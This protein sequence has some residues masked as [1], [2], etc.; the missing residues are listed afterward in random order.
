MG[1]DRV[2]WSIL[3]GQFARNKFLFEGLDYNFSLLLGRFVVILISL[4]I[5]KGAPEVFDF[6]RDD[7]KENTEL[8]IDFR[9]NPIISKIINLF[10]RLGLYE[11]TSNISKIS[12]Q[13]FVILLV[14]MVLSF[15]FKKRYLAVLL[16]FIPINVISDIANTEKNP[17]MAEVIRST[18]YYPKQLLIA[19]LS[20]VLILL[21]VNI[22]TLLTHLIAVN[23]KAMAIV[24]IGCVFISSCAI[25][26]LEVIK[27]GSLFQFLYLMLIY[28]MMDSRI[29]LVDFTGNNSEY[30]KISWGYNYL[31]I[32]VAL[33]IPLFIIRKLRQRSGVNYGNN[34]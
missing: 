33:I 30:F 20:C 1:V 19:W 24:V 7:I 34:M 16:F 21:F 9:N 10:G 18:N 8:E 25:F 6:F 3:G 31:I 13:N 26:T 14:V 12:S 17:S 28:V 22:P 15:F 2:G 4:W 32:S 11:I 5:L 29:Y 23:G 27:N